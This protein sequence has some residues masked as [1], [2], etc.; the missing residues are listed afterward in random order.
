MNFKVIFLYIIICIAGNTSISGQI[1][2]K[3]IT[4][5]K[6][7]LH[8]NI[9]FSD[10]FIQKTG[11]FKKIDNYLKYINDSLRQKGYIFNR[12][13]PDSIKIKHQQ[14]FI[15]YHAELLYK[16]R[17][18][19]IIIAGDLSFPHS[20]LKKI[21]KEFK[22]KVIQTQT[23]HKLLARLNDLSSFS[24][25]EP[26]IN[27]KNGRNLIV[28]KARHISQNNIGGFLGFVY[29]QKQKAIKLEG[30]IETRL[31]NLF[32]ANESLQL[33]WQKKESFQNLDWSI[34]WPFVNGT[35]T[36]F[37][38]HFYMNRNDTLSLQIMNKTGINWHLKNH[39]AGI[40]STY[41]FKSISGQKS[42]RLTYA[43]IKYRFNF[44]K[45]HIKRYIGTDI[46]VDISQIRNI[47]YF[48]NIRYDIIAS[49]SLKYVPVVQIMFNRS[50]QDLSYEKL[51]PDIF[52]KYITENKTYK[53]IFS[54]KNDL[55]Y[56]I[57]T[58]SFYI[59]GDYIYKKTIDNLL[60]T[61]VNTGAGLKILNKN[62]ILTFEIIKV[63]NT[64]YL[65][66]YQGVYINIKQTWR[67]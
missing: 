42:Q 53:Q 64:S 27:F 47:L 38:N 31:Y 18:D 45:K 25:E 7:T 35:N 58:T 33:K 10:V 13:V 65:T 52:R 56:T 12:L 30:A 17:V 4:D 16:R 39:I 6:D 49:E 5:N 22:T 29:D 48:G 66:D 57:K 50:N 2:R 20:I 19:S 60:Y 32:N 15:Y 8:L 3:P 61:Y 40:N 46:E 67:F 41:N 44:N 34:N 1:I 55:R 21:N 62:Q 43:G 24:F 26:V 23:L 37:F 51:H 63:L 59:I 54:F 28:I 11:T 36:S 9:T 14:T